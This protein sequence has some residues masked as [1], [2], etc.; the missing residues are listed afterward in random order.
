MMDEHW[1]QDYANHY[2]ITVKEARRRE[3]KGLAQGDNPLKPICLGC[4]NYPEELSEF[5]DPA[6]DEGITPTEYVIHNE[7][8]YNNRNGHFLCSSC[9]IING[10]PSSERGWVCP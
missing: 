9:Y 7:G 5:I 4:A 8:T 6:E 10:M 2:K 1:I 3:A